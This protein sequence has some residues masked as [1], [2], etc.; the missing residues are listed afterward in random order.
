MLEQRQLLSASPFPQAVSIPLTAA[1]IGSTSGKIVLVRGVSTVDTYSFTSP[2]TGTLVLRE[3]SGPGSTAFPTVFTLYN[4]NGQAINS[5]YNVA[6]QPYF[7]LDAISATKN[8]VYYAKVAP[9]GNTFG[10]YSIGITPDGTGNTFAMAAPITLVPVGAGN[11]AG[12]ATQAG[13]IYYPGDVNYFSFTATVTGSLTIT[14]TASRASTVSPALSVYNAAKTQM[15]QGGTSG[16][17]SA[18][19]TVPVVA[20]SSY[21]VEAAANLSTTGA[22]ALQFATSP[23]SSPPVGHTFATATSIPVPVTTDATGQVVQPLS[24]SGSQT[25]TINFAGDVD[26]YS[27]LSPVNGQMTITQKAATGSALDSHLYIYDANQKLI[28]QND[29]YNSTLNSFVS[30]PV[31]AGMKYYAEATGHDASTGAYM[32]CF[33]A[34]AT[35]TDSKGMISTVAAQ[36]LTNQTALIPV[37]ISA[38]LIALASDGTSTSLGAIE[39]LG[40]D[41]LYSVVAPATGTF[42]FRMTPTSGNLRQHVYIYGGS[43]VV[44]SQGKPVLDS[45]GNPTLPLLSDGTGD[46]SANITQG[47]TYYVEAAGN[48]QTAG[49]YALQTFFQAWMGIEDP[50]LIML[51]KQLF[52]RDGMINREDMMQI[53]N[54]TVSNSFDT[55]SAMDF[56]DLKAIVNVDSTYLKMPNYVKVLAGDIVNGSPANQYFTG[57]QLMP[58]FLGSLYAGSPATQ[59]DELIG[60][61]FLGTDMPMSDVPGQYYAA[62]KGVL[63]GSVNGVPTPVLTDAQQGALGD[64]YFISSMTGIARINPTAIENMIQYNGLDN[65]TPSWTVRFYGN[66]VADYVTV[67]NEL[68]T[69][70]PADAVAGVVSAGALLYDGMWTITNPSSATNVLWL[71]LLEKAYAQWNEVGHEEHDLVGAGPDG[72]NAYEAVA[73]GVMTYVY[74]QVLGPYDNSQLDMLPGTPESVLQSALANNQVVT[75]GTLGAGIDTEWDTDGLYLSHAYTVVGYNAS[76][77]LYTLHNPWGNAPPDPGGPATQPPP[78]SWTQ[79]NNDCDAI[80]IG[81]AFVSQ[82]FSS[83]PSVAAMKTPTQPPPKVRPVL[84]TTGGTAATAAAGAWYAMNSAEANSRKDA[85]PPATQDLALLAYLS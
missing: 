35:T 84:A 68:P 75:I 57:G 51:V 60:K 5:I 54:Y 74:D 10:S 22:Y 65:G 53:L 40:D 83:S 73:A 29:N 46:V 42:N 31:A 26:Y 1:G 37:P 3:I 39:F 15:A 4:A 77:K 38:T 78:L 27:F 50:G 20:G 17:L 67:N 21:Y 76:T 56:N 63:Y 45:N 11:N 80:C 61:W 58:S 19:V 70:P 79:L 69:V 9:Q 52:A 25:G 64:C 55:L 8:S 32:L 81:N 7:T 62:V 72:V 43:V 23:S 36:I 14:Q 30:I 66:G 18:S 6:T 13:T 49:A 33:S 16:K 59:M 47:N 34:T 82:P 12:S 41:D 28:W 44:D 85:P 48:G 2:L 71:P 24:A